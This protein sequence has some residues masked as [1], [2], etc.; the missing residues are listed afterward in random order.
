MT[1]SLR[2]HLRLVR[3]ATDELRE[4]AG[5]LGLVERYL[6]KCAERGPRTFTPLQMQNFARLIREGRLLL[7]AIRRDQ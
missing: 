7:E 2:P 5:D 4:T 6:E 1:T 3:G